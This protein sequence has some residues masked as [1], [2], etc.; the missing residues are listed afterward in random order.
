MLVGK[1]WWRAN[2]VREHIR[3][4]ED[5]MQYNAMQGGEREDTIR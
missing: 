1:Q 5:A 4:R 3:V 2:S